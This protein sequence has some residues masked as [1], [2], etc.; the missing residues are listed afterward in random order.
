MPGAGGGR[1]GLLSRPEPRAEE[2]FRGGGAPHPGG[3][4]LTF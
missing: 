4:G 3:H 1:G 2:S